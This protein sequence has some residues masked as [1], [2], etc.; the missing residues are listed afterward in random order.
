MIHVRAEAGKNIKSAMDRKPA[1]RAAGYP[2]A[3]GFIFGEC[4]IIKRLV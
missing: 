3:G 4:V 2:Q 1:T